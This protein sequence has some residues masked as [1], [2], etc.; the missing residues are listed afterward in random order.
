MSNLVSVNG[1]GDLIEFSDEQKE[2]IKGTVAQGLSD[3]EF[4]FFLEVAKRSGLDPFQRQI[5]AVKRQG[6]LC[7]QTGID[8]FRVIAAR[9]REYA[10]QEEKDFEYEGNS[11]FPTKARCTVYR[12]VQGH[13]VSFTAT[14]RWA[15]F[16]PGDKQGFMWRDKPEVMLGKC[17]EA[18]AL[19]MAFPA[20]TK[21]LYE[22]AE[23]Q[24]P[25]KE[26]PTRADLLNKPK[27]IP[28]VVEADT[29]DLSES[30]ETSEGNPSEVLIKGKR[31]ADHTTEELQALLD[32][33]DKNK[34]QAKKLKPQI[35][36]I[37]A[38]L[39][40]VES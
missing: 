26:G 4:K 18:Q 10:G 38:H 24:R 31:V 40:S 1:N 22:E 32:W 25:V 34:Y 11:K 33:A 28:E 27:D 8:G 30:E 29:S 16:Y 39:E 17:V 21:G 20:E 5:H 19:R 36:A 3:F 35:D 9:T 2:I 13:R 14:C 23:L 15:E 6:K 37:Y 7:I 12:L